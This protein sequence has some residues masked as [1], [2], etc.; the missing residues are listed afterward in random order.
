[1]NSALHHSLHLLQGSAMAKQLGAEAYLECSAFTSEKS[2]HSVFRTA[3]MACINKLQPLPKTSPTRRLSKRLLHLPSKSDL[4][5]STFKKEKAKSCSVMWVETSWVTVITCD[6]KPL[7]LWSRGR[8]GGHDGFI[9][10]SC[11]I[12]PSP[13]R[14]PNTPQ[15]RWT[16]RCPLAPEPFSAHLSFSTT[17][18]LA[19]EQTISVKVWS[20]SYH[21]FTCKQYATTMVLHLSDFTI[22]RHMLILSKLEMCNVWRLI[23]W[24]KCL[25]DNSMDIFL[26]TKLYLAWNC[27]ELAKSCTSLLVR[28]VRCEIACRWCPH[29]GLWK[30]RDAEGVVGQTTVRAI[31]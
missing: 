7:P 3:A 31:T 6:P 8:G 14:K 24:C 25:S 9:R 20:S 21:F 26:S 4:L 16:P 10:A 28:C 27:Q 18:Y 1:M 5:S 17:V 29:L 15:K 12:L 11:W 19:F 22:S 30:H 13:P 2:I 23:L